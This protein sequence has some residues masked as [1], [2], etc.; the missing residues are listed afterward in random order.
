MNAQPN[1]IAALFDP[2]VANARLR[3]QSVCRAAVVGT[4]VIGASWVAL[5][6]ACGLEVTATD[7]APRAA[8]ELDLFLNSAWPTLVQLGAPTRL[9]R[10]RLRFAADL[11]TA[12]DGADWVQE[13]GPERLEAKRDLFTRLDRAAPATAILAS[14]SSGLL[15][16]QFQDAC[17]RHPERCLIGHPFNPPHLI[18]LVELVGGPMTAPTAV[19]RAEAFYRAL[20]KTTIRVRKE[21]P[22]HVGN[23]LA[24]ALW[25]EFVHL[26]TEDVASVAD[27]DIAVTAALG[28][29]WSIM[30]PALTYHLG[31]GSGGIR[32]FLTH[33]GGPFEQW[34][35]TLGTPTLTPDVKEKLVAGVESEQAGQPMSELTKRRDQY[36]LQILRTVQP[37]VSTE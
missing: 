19:D 16:S 29:R 30:G 6:L 3:E 28:L 36:L 33:L 10:D 15:P 20:G 23:R 34:W 32:D 7:I 27:L 4:G 12:V 9:P 22:G 37:I 21:V 2:S 11:E 26:A 31:G 17:A 1:S 8:S 13:N 24:A 35:A 14:S 25:R 5:F 18:P